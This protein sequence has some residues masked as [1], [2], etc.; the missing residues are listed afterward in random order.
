[1]SCQTC[2]RCEHDTVMSVCGKTSVMFSAQ[3]QD[4]E[5]DG[6]VLNGF[7]IS[8]GSGDYIQF[9]MCINCGQI[10]GQFPI[11]KK[12]IAQAFKGGQ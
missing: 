8:D 2:Q 5:Y 7:N 9:K 11:L 3:Y 4:S 6:Y 1:M 10:Q 12:Y